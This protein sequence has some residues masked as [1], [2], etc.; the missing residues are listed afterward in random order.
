MGACRNKARVG[1]L[2]KKFFDRHNN[3][4]IQKW[5]PLFAAF[6]ADLIH[7]QLVEYLFPEPNVC[8]TRSIRGSISTNFAHEHA[9]FSSCWW[10][11][12]AASTAKSGRHF[13]TI[14]KQQKVCYRCCTTAIEFSLLNYRA[15]DESF[16]F[17]FCLTKRDVFDVFKQKRNLAER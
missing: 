7:Q 8:Y 14:L 6:P 11:K 5:P 16:L 10:I 17:P 15:A 1:K 9:Y 4:S 12:S 2:H 3:E 13:W